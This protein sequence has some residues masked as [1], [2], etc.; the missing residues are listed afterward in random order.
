MNFHELFSETKLV[1]ILRG[2]PSD[3]LFELLDCLYESGIRLAEINYD[4]TDDIPDEVVA[5]IAAAVAAMST[6]GKQYAIRR[7]R[8][9]TAT[10]VRPAWAAAGIADNTRPF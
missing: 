2:V 6:D 9:A 4:A 3:Q 7:I 10:G 8:P 5:V 1:A